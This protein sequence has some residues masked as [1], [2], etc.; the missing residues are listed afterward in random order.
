M[1][2]NDYLSI[3]K[4]RLSTSRKDLTP[5]TAQQSI[6]AALIALVERLDLIISKDEWNEGADALRVDVSRRDW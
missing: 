1:G 4:E 3:A 6:A 2:N 5:Y